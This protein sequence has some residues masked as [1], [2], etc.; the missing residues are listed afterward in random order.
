[1]VKCTQ[2]PSVK[3]CGRIF[4]ISQILKVGVKSLVYHIDIEQKHNVLQKEEYL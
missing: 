4:Y 1:M 3:K 2:Y